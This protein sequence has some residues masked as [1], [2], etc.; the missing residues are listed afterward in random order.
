MTQQDASDNPN[1]LPPRGSV[2]FWQTRR[3]QVTA[4]GLWLTGLLIVLV[5]LA[6]IGLPQMRF[7]ILIVYVLTALLFYNARRAYLKLAERLSELRALN[8]IG[9]GRGGIFL[10]E[11]HAA[12][13]GNP[14]AGKWPDSEQ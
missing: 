1:H 10:P 8:R 6:Y 11:R 5:A 12:I 7:L 14:G 3:G 9:V 4:L 13:P 2:G